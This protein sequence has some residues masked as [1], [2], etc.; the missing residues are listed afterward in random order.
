MTG[1]R[2]RGLIAA[3]LVTVVVPGCGDQGGSNGPAAPDGQEIETARPGTLTA[4]LD[5][6]PPRGGDDLQGFEVDLV[7]ELAR[8]LGLEPGVDAVESGRALDELAA[9]DVD[10]VVPATRDAARDAEAALSAPYLP[11]GQ[12]LTVARGSDIQSFDALTGQTVGAVRGASGAEYAGRRTD[13]ARVRRY[14]DL[15]D[16]LD[17]LRGGQVAGVVHDSAASRFAQRSD[18]AIEVVETAATGGDYRLAVGSDSDALL[19]AVDEALAE[20]KADG[21]Y[22]RIYRTW[23]DGRPPEEIVGADR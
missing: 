13:A 5:V 4:E 6:P 11:A 2:L 20:I 19:A 22:E 18:R 16:A 1:P 8:R 15:P 10:L 12:S 7:E 17:A 21:T 9:G 3:V 14:A 23:L